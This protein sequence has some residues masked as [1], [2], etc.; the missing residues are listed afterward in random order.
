MWYDCL[1]YQDSTTVTKVLLSEIGQRVVLIDK[2][3]H[4]MP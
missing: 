3:L 1:F 4:R 2:Y